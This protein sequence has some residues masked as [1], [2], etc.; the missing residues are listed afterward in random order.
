MSGLPA[1]VPAGRVNAVFRQDERQRTPA[2]STRLWGIRSI[3]APFGKL[4]YP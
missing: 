4:R 2:E 3:C 1:I